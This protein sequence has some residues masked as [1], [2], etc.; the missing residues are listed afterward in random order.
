[1]NSKHVRLTF[2]RLD[3]IEVIDEDTAVFEAECGKGTYV[4]AIA[5]DLGRHL[6]TRGHVIN[7][8]RTV[9]G[10]FDEEDMI[11]LDNLREMSNS[12]PADEGR[13]DAFSEALLPVET[14]LD[15]IPAL[16]VNGNDAARLKRGQAI[17]LRGRDAP[18]LQGTAYVTFQGNL[19][20]LG[21]VSGG[22]LAPKR[23]FNPLRRISAGTPEG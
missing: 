6:K 23:V 18:V 15:D 11:S 4:R 3:L 7:L 22:E 5:R 12:A 13:A 14:A 20:A 8:R 10:P 9:V 2:H 16:A 19:I 21:D 17:L 1:M